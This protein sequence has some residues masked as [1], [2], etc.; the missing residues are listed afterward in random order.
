MANDNKNTNELVIN[1]DEPTAE[2]ETLADT[3]VFKPPA[4]QDELPTINELRSDLRSRTETIDRLQ[5]DI[6]HLRSRWTGLEAEIKER[7]EVTRDLNAK[8]ALTKEQL[9]R[10]ER[11]LRKRDQTI[12]ALKAEIRDRNDEYGTLNTTLTARE[13]QLEDLQKELDKAETAEVF[14]DGVDEERLAGRLAAANA[15][16]SQLRDRLAQ[17][18]HYADKLRRQLQQHIE[19]AQESGA[20]REALRYSLERSARKGEEL[21]QQVEALQA[22]NESLEDKLSGIR[23]EHEEEIRLIRFELGEAQETVAQHELVTEQLASDLVDTRGFRDELEKMLTRSEEQSGSRIGD[24]EC[25]NKRLKDELAHYQEELESKSDAINCL[26]AE[27]AKK[28]QQLETID[29]I[30]DVIQ[31]IDDRM[32]ERIEDREHHERD[33]MSRVLIG[34]VGEQELQFPL[35]KD[36]LTIGRTEHNDIQLKSSCISR[37]HAVIVVDLNTTRIIDWGSKNGLFVNSE[38]VTEHFL[39]SGDS[40]RIGTADFRYE[41]RPKRDI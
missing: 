34:T 36:R 15:E 29:E 1:D 23:Q 17:A 27:M 35:F 6:E 12:K 19:I 9:S 32:S 20:A 16:S 33:R 10:K 11:L 28:S 38:K 21:E 3:Y 30:E 40:V 4:E 5:Y 13:Q 14:S 31:D 26:L 25:E 41:E 7:Q 39:K 8:L 2:L 37:R 18:D 22:K 24:L